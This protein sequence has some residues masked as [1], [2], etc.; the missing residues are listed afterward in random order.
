MTLCLKSMAKTEV[1]INKS[2]EISIMQECAYPEADVIV[3]LP[4]ERARIVAAELI[5]LAFELEDL[6]ATEADKND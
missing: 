6:L 2:D 5:R 4:P 1:F 3:S